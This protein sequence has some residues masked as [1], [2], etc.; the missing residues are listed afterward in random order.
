MAG[1]A[2]GASGTGR[3]GGARNVGGVGGVGR[4]A[5]VRIVG[6]AAGAGHVG[7]AGGAGVTG[8]AGGA[9]GAVGAAD[10]GGSGNLVSH[11]V[12]QGNLNALA[13]VAHLF[14]LL[15]RTATCSCCK[16]WA[17][18]EFYS[19]GCFHPAVVVVGRRKRD[20]MLQEN[21]AGVAKA[22]EQ[23]DATV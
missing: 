9:S 11:H 1:G 15:W 21:A 2:G 17:E 22:L 18:D 7:V 3:V 6:G 20:R 12:L 8:G 14:N 23:R 16:S 19:A 10:V 13:K 4:G 5:G